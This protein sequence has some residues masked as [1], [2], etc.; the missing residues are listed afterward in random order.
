MIPP[1]GPNATAVPMVL[2]APNSTS[3][4]SG[5]SDFETFLVM[6][7]TQLK[8][9]DPLNPME[10]T[11]FAVQ[12]ATFSGVEQQV[13]TNQLLEG[14]M[15]QTA[16]A[17]LA[18]LVGMTARAAVPAQ[19]DGSAITLS[20]QFPPGTDA[21]QLVVRNALGGEVDRVA[22]DLARSAHDWRGLGADGMPL[23]DGLYSFE[24]ASYADGALFA[25]AP[26]E[27]Y[28]PVVEARRDGS[29]TTLVLAGGVEVDAGAVTALRAPIP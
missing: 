20:V 5:Q 12:L 13:R 1:T 14:M 7:T 6:L 23:P 4:T 2:P 3:G 11:D 16:L 24:I 22:L 21:A 10:A 19:F 15:S 9:Q 29:S 8:H 25:T 27:V 28:A 18:G 26:A 17:E